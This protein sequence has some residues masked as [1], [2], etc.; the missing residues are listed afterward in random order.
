MLKISELIKMLCGIKEKGN[1]FVNFMDTRCSYA[2]VNI[3][4][5]LQKMKKM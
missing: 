3:C 4:V 5:D 2:L 1:N